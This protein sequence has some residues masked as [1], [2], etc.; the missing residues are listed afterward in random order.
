VLSVSAYQEYPYEKIEIGSSLK[1]KKEYLHDICKFFILVNMQKLMGDLKKE[2]L[3]S[4][5]IGKGFSL[6]KPLT[7]LDERFGIWSR[8]IWEGELDKV[9]ISKAVE[10][11]ME[12]LI[13]NE[14]M[15]KDTI[16]KLQIGYW[17][18]SKEAFYKLQSEMIDELKGAKFTEVRA[19]M[20]AYCLLITF[21]KFGI[22]DDVQDIDEFFDDILSKIT[23][24]DKKTDGSGYNNIDSMDLNFGGYRGYQL[25]YSSD[26]DRA[27]NF[28]SKLKGEYKKAY[29]IKK[30][31]T[32]VNL[33]E[34][35]IRG[36][37]KAQTFIDNIPE[38]KPVLE[39]IGSKK[40][41]E[42][43]DRAEFMEQRQLFSV[44]TERYGVNSSGADEWYLVYKSELGIL[45]DFVNGYNARY[46]KAKEDR[47]NKV[48][49]YSLLKDDSIRV[50]DGFKK[51]MEKGE[52]IIKQ[53]EV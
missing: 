30:S 24:T 6:F 9:A 1:D 53:R 20:Q 40:L 42:V 11:D 48:H 26:K 12:A 47:D 44:L 14:I 34:Q 29:K 41:W 16:Y 32:I 3:W 31:E 38:Q 18:Y 7:Q 52:K 45:E 51:K 17:D 46:D 43:L 36:E 23:L 15:E 22:I 50:L 28:L 39:W 35:I 49:I 5:G 33:I 19:I 37:E 8:Y 2:Y 25:Y 27:S 13:P 10:K 21:E 4:V